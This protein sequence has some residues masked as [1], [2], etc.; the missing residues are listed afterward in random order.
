MFGLYNLINNSMDSK[1]PN[2]DIIEP[3][4]EYS[5]LETRPISIDNK[6]LSEERGRSPIREK[7]PIRSSNSRPRSLSIPINRQKSRSLSPNIKINVKVKS[8]SLSPI[9]NG[10]PKNMSNTLNSLW[11]SLKDGTL[12]TKTTLSV[13][14]DQ[15]IQLDQ[16]DSLIGFDNSN[17]LTEDNYIKTS[18]KISNLSESSEDQPVKKMPA[19]KKEPAK[20]GP[21]KKAISK[22]E[23]LKKTVTVKSVYK[24]PV[25][26]KKM[27]ETD[28]DSEESYPKKKTPAKGKKAYD[29]TEES[30]ESYQKKSKRQ[31]A[32]YSSS[33]EERVYYS[34]N[35]KTKTPA[36]KATKKSS[37][38]TNESLCEIKSDP[39]TRFIE[40]LDLDIAEHKT[41]NILLLSLN[42]TKLDDENVSKENTD[43]TTQKIKNI[44]NNH[45]KK[46]S[47]DTTQ[48]CILILSEI[49][50]NNLGDF[51]LKFSDDDK[52][53]I[54]CQKSII[55]SIPYFSMIFEDVSN[56]NTINLQTDNSV[57]P[58]YDITKCIIK[59]LY[60]PDDYEDIITINN[61]ILIFEQMN[62]WLMKDQ[63]NIML[64]FAKTNIKEIINLH[65]KNK[66]INNIVIL[67]NILNSIANEKFMENNEF[68]FGNSKKL[69]S[70]AQDILDIMFK[71]NKNKWND[72]IFMFENWNT[73]F[74]DKDKLN[75]IHLSK[76]YELLNIA[77]VEP[78]IIIKFLS[79]LDY[80][81]DCYQDMLNISLYNTFSRSLDNTENLLDDDEECSVITNYYPEFSYLSFEILYIKC[82]R[83]NDNTCAFTFTFNNNHHTL[84]IGSQLLVITGNYSKLKLSDKYTDNIFTIQKII[85]SVNRKD[86]FGPNKGIDAFD[87][88]SAKYAPKTMHSV[89][90]KII[91][92]KPL[93]QI[94][95]KIK[96]IYKCKCGDICFESE[97]DCECSCHDECEE[98][99]EISNVLTMYL[100]KN[101][102]SIND[103]KN[104]TNTKI[105]S[106][107]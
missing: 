32:K 23:P 103:C 53:D 52:Y 56:E 4:I 99:E 18:K 73:L 69:K 92:D 44:V 31:K 7:S 41:I 55:K 89:S 61:F 80:K 57:L 90:Y 72:Y 50:T 84:N 63:F 66:N 24:K 81:N 10:S 75:A 20:K 16:K 48:K 100:I 102:S 25:Y 101:H 34:K 1:K 46:K 83:D 85:K 42:Y 3:I 86:D 68:S 76:K 104:W 95:P 2:S 70:N 11:Q 8:R 62:I 14:P 13:E 12:I 29:I 67:S 36:K 106:P 82:K 45:I 38:K 28:S 5:E 64:K 35:K 65:F 97:E 79:N 49:Y 30:E 21:V 88:E 54:K 15:E 91:L 47:F 105:N 59:L 93:P 58:N 87:V 27:V 19:K 107:K 22:K 17:Q 96:K 9:T 6:S 26:K 71:N 60:T 33:E 43:E 39:L 94:E 51:T 98:S 77:N 78:N 74:S 37:K 40:E